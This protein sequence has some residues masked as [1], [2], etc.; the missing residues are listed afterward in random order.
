MGGRFDRESGRFGAKPVA[1]FTGVRMMQEESVVRVA[2]LDD[3]QGVSKALGDWSILPPEVKVHV[4]QDH[5]AE[6]DALVERLK[7]FEVIVGMR[8]L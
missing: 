8:E 1:D 5:L 3:Y 7:G 2:V 4:F 6:E